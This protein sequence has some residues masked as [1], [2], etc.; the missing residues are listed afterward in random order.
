M[1]R[2]PS[3]STLLAGP[4]VL[5]VLTTTPA[6]SPDARDAASPRSGDEGRCHRFAVVYVDMTM[7]ASPGEPAQGQPE[8]DPL[9]IAAPLG[10]GTDG[11]VVDTSAVKPSF[12]QPSMSH[13]HGACVRLL[14]SIRKLCAPNKSAG[15]DTCRHVLPHTYCTAKM[16]CWVG[17]H[18]VVHGVGKRGLHPAHTVHH[19]AHATV[20]CRQQLHYSCSSAALR[21]SPLTC[22]RIVVASRLPRP[23]STRRPTMCHR[24][25]P[26]PHNTRH[27]NVPRRSR[28]WP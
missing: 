12:S 3:A 24:P 15:N 4:A 1:P 25:R 8:I 13:K 23:P 26:A 11:G 22:Y 28:P 21:P 19:G 5:A 16:L 2:V 6:D 27:N 14:D 17:V 18:T 7:I 9:V 20:H 10:D